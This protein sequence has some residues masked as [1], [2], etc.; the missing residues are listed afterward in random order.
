MPDPP[1][2]RSVPITPRTTTRK[3][4][5]LPR[6]NIRNLPALHTWLEATHREAPAALDE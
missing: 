6:E 4:L 1:W 3:R 2:E 5:H